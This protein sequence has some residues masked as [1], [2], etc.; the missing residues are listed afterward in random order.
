MVH[1]SAGVGRSGVVV[2]TEM[3]M[4]KVDIGEVR[5]ACAIVSVIFQLPLQVIDIPSCLKDLRQQ[6]MVLVQ[7]PMQYKFVYMALL[8]YIQSSRL[9]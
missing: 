1:C 4:D 8:R 3:L 9:I 5:V 2:L 6:R 7:T